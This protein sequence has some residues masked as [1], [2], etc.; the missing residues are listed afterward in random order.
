MVALKDI[1]MRYWLR[2]NA[3]ERRTILLGAAVLLIGVAY[4]YLWLPVTRDRARLQAALPGLRAQAARVA[5]AGEEAQ[6]LKA[7]A[8]AVSVDQAGGIQQILE[9]SLGTEMR[10]GVERIAAESPGRATLVISGVAFDKWA[11]WVAQ[12]HSRDHVRLESC[13]IETLAQ[14]GL[15][16]IQA[17]MTR[18]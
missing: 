2:L 5:A 12:V 11:E 1:L 9:N 17:V 14:G 10:R 18:G 3:S 8:S 4:A 13:V 7:S 15:V 16:R 6:R